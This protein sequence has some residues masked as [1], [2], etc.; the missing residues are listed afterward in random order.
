MELPSIPTLGL[1]S[2]LSLGLFVSCA[3]TESAEDA[4]LR[5]HQEHLGMKIAT[6]E[7]LDIVRNCVHCREFHPFLRAEKIKD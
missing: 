4:A 6:E 7:D 2:L 5:V 1:T 3:S